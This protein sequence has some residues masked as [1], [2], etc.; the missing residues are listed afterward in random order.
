MPPIAPRSS[1]RGRKAPFRC[2]TATHI[3]RGRI[4]RRCRTISATA[5]RSMASATR[6]SPPSRPPAR[7]RCSPDNV[8]SGIEPVFAFSYS[9]KVLQPDGSK[10][11]ETVEDYAVAQIPRPLR[12][13]TRRC[14]IISSPPRRSRR[15]I[16]W[17]CRRRRSLSSTAPFP[18]PSMC[19]RDF[20]RG[21]QGCL[22]RGL[23]RR[24]QGLHHLSPQ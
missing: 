13:R 5:S 8:S 16:I 4:S 24:L 22:S 11:E 14:P 6:C 2:S 23:S 7:F 12:R 1:W 21:L 18:R 20:L 10:R 9:R 17:R 19:R 15:Q 3:W